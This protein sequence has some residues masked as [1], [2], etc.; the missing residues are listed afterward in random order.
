MEQGASRFGNKTWRLSSHS[1]VAA[2]LDRSSASELRSPWTG[3]GSC[4]SRHL[5]ADQNQILP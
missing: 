3:Q 5:L 4:P 2:A 1:R